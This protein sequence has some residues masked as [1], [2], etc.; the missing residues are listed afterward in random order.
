MNLSDEAAR[1]QD[2]TSPDKETRI[3]VDKLPCE[4]IVIAAQ[5]DTSPCNETRLQEHTSP[6]HAIRTQSHTLQSSSTPTVDM[7]NQIY[8]GKMN[9]NQSFPILIDYLPSHSLKYYSPFVAANLIHQWTPKYMYIQ[10]SNRSNIHYKLVLVTRVVLMKFLIG[11]SY[12]PCK[13]TKMYSIIRKYKD[14]DITTQST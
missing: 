11:F 9:L 1:T 10:P 7:L 6:N 14:K 12:V 2:D 8:T 13:Q 3:E 5:V 4:A